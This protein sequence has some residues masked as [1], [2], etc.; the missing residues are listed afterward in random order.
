[1]SVKTAR[2]VVVTLG[3]SKSMLAEAARTV[4][5][6]AEKIERLQSAVRAADGLVL[7]FSGLPPRTDFE[8]A[9]NLAPSDM[10]APK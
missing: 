8:N 9:Y 1:M 4:V 10:E 2:D 6:Q 7:T 3:A 5:A